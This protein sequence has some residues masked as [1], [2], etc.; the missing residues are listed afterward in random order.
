MTFEEHTMSSVKNGATILQGHFETGN[1][2][3]AHAD[4]LA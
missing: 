4:I 1:T 3:N 2:A